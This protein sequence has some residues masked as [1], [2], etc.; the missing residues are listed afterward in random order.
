MASAAR[1]A[2]LEWLRRRPTAAS[3][4]RRC[5]SPRVT[6]R[7]DRPPRWPPPVSPRGSA[8][9]SP[10]RAHRPAQSGPVA[11]HP[12]ARCTRP[13]PP[14]RR[15][16]VMPRPRQMP[17]RR[18]RPAAQSPGRAR[19]AQDAAARR[20]RRRPRRRVRRGRRAPAP[21][22]W[23]PAPPRPRLRGGVLW[24]APAEV[25]PRGPQA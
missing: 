16:P 3:G 4:S 1:P 24:T 10:G 13:H 19:A 17:P 12:T 9:R 15:P 20:G 22:G 6:A 2:W 11:P 25:R 8:T 23:P 21:C 5:R 7:A 14:R 18:L